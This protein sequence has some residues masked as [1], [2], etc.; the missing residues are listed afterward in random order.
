[1]GALDSCCGVSTSRFVVLR[2]SGQMLAEGFLN[3]RICGLGLLEEETEREL[4]KSRSRV[5]LT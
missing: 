5:Y 4:E 2:R 3:R 1:M